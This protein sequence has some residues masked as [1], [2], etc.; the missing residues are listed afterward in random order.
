MQIAV[1]GSSGRTGI[2]FVN[3]ALEKGHSIRAGIHRQNKL[4]SHPN[5]LA[6]PC[7]TNHVDE[8]KTL[9]NGCH[10]VVSLIGH[11]KDSPPDVQTRG[12]RNTIQAMQELGIKRLVSLTGTGVRFKFDKITLA[13]RVL[14]LGISIIDP[15]RVEDGKNH[16]ELLKNSGLD[17][18]LIRVLKLQ[19]THPM[20]FE[21]K[22]N[23]PTKLY[24]SRIE[25]CAAILQVLE[26]GTFI[27]RAPIVSYV[28]RRT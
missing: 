3:A 10:A 20:L 25:V 22:D 18:T 17:W 7:D 11:T 14:N 4:P 27:Q 26:L 8:I 9:I 13:D 21:L 1:I 23:G 6:L 5:L 15:K 19:N 28:S 24:V 12:T 2:V 16:V